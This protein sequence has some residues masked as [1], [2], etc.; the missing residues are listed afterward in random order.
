MTLTLHKDM[1]AYYTISKSPEGP[2][3]APVHLPKVNDMA[4]PNGAP[5][6]SVPCRNQTRNQSQGCHNIG[7]M[8]LSP[9]LFENGSALAWGRWS[10]F[11]AENWRD[12]LSW[13]NT[14]QAPDFAIPPSAVHPYGAWEGEDPDLWIDA[15]G[16]FHIL[17]HAGARGTF[18]CGRHQFSATGSAGTWLVAGG[19][20]TGQPDGDIGGCAFPRA[21]VGT[22]F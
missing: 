11:R 15:K 12:P 22:L 9:V 8:N 10:I 3:S 6:T 4:G 2:W 1:D 16:R 7:G 5:P 20:R 18:D 13:R 21:N 19:N 14:G 17:S